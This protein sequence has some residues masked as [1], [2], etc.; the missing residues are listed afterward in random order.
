MIGVE[1]TTFSTTWLTHTVYETKGISPYIG[2]L[3]RFIMLGLGLGLGYI[4]FKE[5]V[6]HVVEKAVRYPYRVG[7]YNN[8]VPFAG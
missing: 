1:P 7:R 6:N 5:Y 4:S 8:R 3:F 2:W